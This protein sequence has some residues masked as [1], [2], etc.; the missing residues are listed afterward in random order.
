M[1]LF[2][3]AAVALVVGV[4]IGAVGIGG[5][6]LIPA[7]H[8][9][10]G[11]DVHSASATALFTFFFTGLLGTALFQRRGS[12]DWAMSAT[13]CATAIFSG[14]LG[15]AAKFLINPALLSQIIALIIIAAGAYILLPLSTPGGNLRAAAQTPAL[16]L[17]ILLAVGAV[18]GFGSGL[19]GAGGPVF[20]VPLMLVLGF[21]PLAAIGVSQ[22]LQIVSAASGTLANINYGSIDFAIAGWVTAFELIGVALGVRAAHVVDMVQLRRGAA[23]LCIVVGSAMLIR[24][25]LERP[26]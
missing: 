11:L 7:L 8:V 15:A 19:S 13:V 16:R 24:G 26:W 2:A 17:P 4:F 23:W 21:A 12:I 9:L 14:F 18:A 22:V 10:G 1:I 20:S 3:L 25:A 6:L 5:V